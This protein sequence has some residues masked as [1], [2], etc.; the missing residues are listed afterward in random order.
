[1][2]I[3]FL[4]SIILS[5]NVSAFCQKKENK[6]YNR[7]SITVLNIS[8]E[9]KLDSLGTKK[10]RIKFFDDLRYSK[11]DSV[12]KKFL[13]DQLGK[14]NKVFK[15]YSGNANKNYVGFVYYTFCENNFP[16]EKYYSGGYIEFAFDENEISLQYIDDGEFCF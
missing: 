4:F 5:L 16:K 7:T 10:I 15:F 3:L 1:M 9:W 12:S 8:K 11:V 6:F 14:P 2:R 13:F